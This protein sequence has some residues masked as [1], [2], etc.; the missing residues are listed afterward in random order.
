MEQY[1]KYLKNLPVIPDIAAKILSI[2][3]DAKNISFK[4]LEELIKIDPGLTTKILKVANS[5]LYARQREIT[6]L[7][8]A[9]TLLGFKNIKSLVIL[10]TASNAFA[11]QSKTPFYKDFWKHSV[12]TAFLAKEIARRDLKK[13]SPD[14][15]FLAGLLHD[16]GQVAMFHVEPEEY[17]ELLK[18]REQTGAQT[19]FLEQ[20]RFG[21]NHKQ[22]GASVLAKWSFPDIFVDTAKEHGMINITSE[23]RTLIICISLA[24]IIA[25]M[26]SHEELPERKQKLL[27]EY[28]KL[29]GIPEE[30]LVYY[31]SQFVEKVSE[32]PLFKEC[33]NLFHFTYQ[34]ESKTA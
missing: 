26:I 33:Q 13:L 6:T 28:K 32:D 8:M 15:A 14:E 29:S 21:T 19:K 27:D 24:D 18:A 5:A 10:T 16:I 34:P 22:I 11:G 4:E 31:T 9:I 30:R 7:Q 1:E 12:L 25:D 3:E 2:P 23:H 17:Q 20:E